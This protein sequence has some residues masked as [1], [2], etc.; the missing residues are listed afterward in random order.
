MIKPRVA[1]TA[2]LITGRFSIGWDLV[3]WHDLEY[4]TFYS[5]L[6]TLLEVNTDKMSVYKQVERNLISVGSFMILIIL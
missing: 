6:L 1:L 4:F 5:I 3:I 2:R